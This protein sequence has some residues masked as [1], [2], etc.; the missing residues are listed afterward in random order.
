[1]LKK[2]NCLKD[3]WPRVKWFSHNDGDPIRLVILF[4]YEKELFLPV[5]L[6]YAL[7]NIAPS[8]TSLHVVLD[9]PQVYITRW[10]TQLGQNHV[11][12]ETNFFPMKAPPRSRINYMV[13]SIIQS[14][15]VHFFSAPQCIQTFVLS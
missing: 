6:H 3:S 15:T 14:N 8:E 5:V 4:F 11:C 13:C 12:Y 2:A 1:M 7:G 10:Q 9:A